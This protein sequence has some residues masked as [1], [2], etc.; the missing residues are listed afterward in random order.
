[1]DEET[2]R[3]A[4]EP[5]F[6]TKDLGRGTCLGLS[7]VNGLADQSGGAMRIRIELGLGT[8]VELWLPASET[9]S[10]D[11]ERAY[12]QSSVASISPVQAIV[13]DDS[14]VRA[15]TAAMIEDLGHSAVKAA[16]AAAAFDVL[17]SPQEIDLVL[18]DYAMPGVT[19][20]RLADQINGTHPSLPVNRL[21]TGHFKLRDSRNGDWTR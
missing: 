2:R 5:F 1:M 3:R 18:T 12:A 20:T 14:M 8:T 6:T 16:S 10:A 11:W 13:V 15:S 19:G 9:R 7:M 17:R 21:Y 4:S